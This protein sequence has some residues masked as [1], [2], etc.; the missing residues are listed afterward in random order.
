MLFHEETL[1]PSRGLIFGREGELLVHNEPIYDVL[2]TYNQLNSQMDTNLFCS[3]L[4]ITTQEFEEKIEKNWKSNRYSKT[5]PYVFLDKVPA[6]IITQFEEHL[7]AFPGMEVQLR[8][9]RKYPFP[10]AA[11]LIGYINEVNQKQISQ[12]EDTYAPGD[13][14][15]VSG[16]ERYYEQFLRGVKGSSF[17]VKDNLGR[18]VGKYSR[19]HKDSVAVSGADLFTSLDLDLQIYGEHL[20]QGKKGGIVALDPRTGEI[21]C[22]VSAPYYD[23]NLLSIGHDRSETFNDLQSD[24]LQPLFNRALMA[25]YPPGSIFK[26]VLSLIA[27]QENI[28]DPS[29][30]IYCPGGYYYNEDFRKCH[31]HPGLVNVEKAL[32]Y[33]CNTFYFQIFR[34][35][36]DKYGFKQPSRGLAD[37][38]QYLLNFGIGAPLAVDLPNET[39]GN[40]PTPEYYDKVYPKEK[41]GWKSPTIMSVGI[42]QGEIEMSILQMANLAAIIGNKGYFYTPHLVRQVLNDRESVLT[43]TDEAAKTINVDSEHFDPVVEGMRKAVAMGT[44]YSAQVPGITVCGKTGTSQNPHGKDHSVFFA[45]APIENPSI[46]IAV[47]VENAGDGNQFAAPISGLM[48]EKHLKGDI[49]EYRKYLETRVANTNLIATP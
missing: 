36:V 46:A 6:E 2:A 5:I 41:G 20:M 4:H 18:V 16:L 38:N 15:G 33:S 42:G 37:L 29:R 27:L 8:T 31:D 32:Q 24:K 40:L 10:H 35:L 43:Q 21:L 49:L 14:I 1:Y 13:Y 12:S 44:G 45:F 28:I 30:Y 23:P 11:H 39:Q 34:E 47:L 17:V 26:S 3:L 9:Y 25:K 7:H 48:I 22:L 19:G